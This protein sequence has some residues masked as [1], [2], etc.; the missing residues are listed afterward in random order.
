MVYRCLWKI[1]SFLGILLALWAYGM[2][3]SQ[4]NL[5]MVYNNWHFATAT[6]KATEIIDVT[7]WIAT[8]SWTTNPKWLLSYKNCNKWLLNDLNN[9]PTLL[10]CWIDLYSVEGD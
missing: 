9:I 10:H 7:K 5:V 6:N 2:L 8:F 1:V 4:A 3:Q